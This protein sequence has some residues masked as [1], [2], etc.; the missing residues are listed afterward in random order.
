MSTD[1]ATA[2]LTTLCRENGI[3]LSA[4]SLHEPVPGVLGRFLAA[5]GGTARAALNQLH[6]HALWRASPDGA[7]TLSSVVAALG[8]DP[9]ALRRQAPHGVV[10]GAAVDGAAYGVLHARCGRLDI[11]G[12]VDGGYA[13]RALPLPLLLLLLV[14]LLA[15]D[16]T[17]ATT[18]THSPAL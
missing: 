14:Q 8:A 1:D 6:E 4:W 16:A 3:D 12:L 17:T 11:D 9:S 10:P 13:K 2:E 18:P 5:H 7:S 15:S